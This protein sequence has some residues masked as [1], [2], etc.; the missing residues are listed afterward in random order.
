[1]IQ[2]VGSRC[3]EN[4]NCSRIC[5]QS[6]VKHALEL[7]KIN[8]DMDVIVLYRD[9]RMYGL[10]EDHYTEA[11]RRGIIFSRFGREQPPRVEEGSGGARNRLRRPC[12]SAV[13]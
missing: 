10:L 2:C 9:M 6:A 8:P 7:K 4:P 1:M 3:D 13:P 5:C 11:R 12:F